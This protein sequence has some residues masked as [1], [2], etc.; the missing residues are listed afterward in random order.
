MHRIARIT[1]SLVVVS[2]FAVMTVTSYAQDAS[3]A[4]LPLLTQSS[5]K[6]LGSFGLPGNDGSGTTQ[7]DLT[8]G[9]QALSVTPAGTLL[10]GGHTWYPTLCEVTIPG[11]GGTATVLQRCTDVTEGRLTQVDPGGQIEY[12]GSLVYGGRLIVSNFSY[13]DADANQATSH[14]ASGTS[15]AT[16]GDVVGPVQVGAAGAGFVSGYM[17]LIPQE[18]QATFGGPALTGNCCLSIISRTSSG[19]AVS[20]FNPDDVGAVSPVPATQLVGYTLARPLADLT[21]KNAMYVRGDAVGGVAFP[22]GTRSVLF[23]GVHG[24]GQ[25]C[26]GEGAACGDPVSSYKGDHAYPY[27]HQ[28]WAYD[29]NDLLAVKNGQRQP[30]DV[31]PYL[32]WQLPEMNNTGSASITGAFYDPITNRIYITENYGANPRV[33]VYQVNGGGTSSTPPATTPAPATPSPTTPEPSAPEPSTPA[34]STPE[35]STPSPAPSVPGAPT[36]LFA[37][38]RGTSVTLWWRS[39]AHRIWR[40]RSRL[41]H[42]VP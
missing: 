11:I 9:G 37:H 31:R 3:L 5:L 40:V 2:L 25:P 12:G 14:F 42:H 30:S 26:Y 6:Y 28:V 34:P 17:G 29:A 36:D 15:L 38:V 21:A 16:A 23:I 13:Y 18:W 4:Q 27:V 10:L 20:V 41:D 35:P 22:T 19:P 24:S 1:A 32:T 8:Y 33:H 7:G 39:S